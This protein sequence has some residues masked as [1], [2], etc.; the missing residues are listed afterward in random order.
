MLPRPAKHASWCVTRGA[1]HRGAGYGKGGKLSDDNKPTKERMRLA[2]DDVQ[3]FVTD[4]GKR[5][6]RMMDSPLDRLAYCKNPKITTAQYSAGS[7]FYADAYGAGLMPGGA[8]D[9]AKERV[10]GG[11]F[12]SHSDFKIA[13]QTRFNHALRILHK[14]DLHIL[15]EVV[16]EEVPLVGYADRL[17]QYREHRVR[18]VVA[19]D[20]LCRALNALD[21]HYCPPARGQSTSQRA[22][23]ADGYR[24][25]IRP[26]DT[27]S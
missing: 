22:A 27:H 5:S 20:R 17:R 9:T 12:E 1:Q 2:G 8:M 15:Q 19:L 3:E 11:G 24:P 14:E 7:R 21:Q 4:T 6:V 23:M 26:R 13:A 18:M 16:L 10:D 25:G